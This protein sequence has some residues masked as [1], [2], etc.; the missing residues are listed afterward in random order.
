MW[1]GPDPDAT[2]MCRRGCTFSTD[3]NRDIEAIHGNI[4]NFIFRLL[5]SAGRRML[6]QMMSRRRMKRRRLYINNGSLWSN[7]CYFSAEE[8]VDVEWEP[9]VMGLWCE[10]LQ[11]NSFFS[12]NFRMTEATFNHDF[13]DFRPA[14]NYE[15]CHYR[16]IVALNPTTGCMSVQTGVTFQKIRSV[17]D[18]EYMKVTQI[19]FEKMRFHVICGVHTAIKQLDH[20]CGG[21]RI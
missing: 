1:N 17:S 16:V 3:V 10:W 4:Y 11:W 8:C 9:G 12:Q 13:C 5:C 15:D 6:K 7:G 20:I 2:R 21:E 19:W 14:H 18:L